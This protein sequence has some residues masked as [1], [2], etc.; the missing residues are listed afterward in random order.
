MVN[1]LHIK[2]FLDKNNI[3]FSF[4]GAISQNLLIDIGEGIES[5]LKEMS[6]ENK[7]ATNI[8]GVFTEQMQNVMNYSTNKIVFSSGTCEGTGIGVMG[9]SE[10]KC[11]YFVGSANFIDEKS[12]LKIEQK[13]NKINSLSRDELRLY[14]RELRKSGKY[15]HEK[16]A[17]LGFL[18]MAKKSTEPID[19]RIVHL[20]NDKI[21]FELFV[22]I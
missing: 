12:I 2:E 14:Y 4:S 19:Y 10:D 16:G 1:L 15:K 13:I 18:E 9:F 3:F 20:E 22:Y 17:G 8:F 6:V 5:K 7:V 11:K 21:L